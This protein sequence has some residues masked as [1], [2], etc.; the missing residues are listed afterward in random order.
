M[1]KIKPNNPL[2]NALSIAL[3]IWI[4]SKCES[5]DNLQIRIYGSTMGIFKGRLSKVELKAKKVNFKNINLNHINLSSGPIQVNINLKGIHKELIS[6]GFYLKGEVFLDEKDLN[7]LIQDKSWNW[8]KG[9]FSEKILYNKK[10]NY[11]SIEKDQ[12]KMIS[13]TDRFREKVAETLIIS[14]Y[15]N[16]ILIYNNNLGKKALFPMDS[17]IKI[18][19]CTISQNNLNILFE[20][21]VK[22]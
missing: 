5:I 22:V 4:K 7:S 9:W 14:E 21:Y 20:S 13:E 17:S 6:K 16:S 19:K 3:E 8:I 12:F 18:K 2:F 11:I 15:E 10:P 1:D